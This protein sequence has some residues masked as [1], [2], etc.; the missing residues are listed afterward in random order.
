[1]MINTLS[2]I[3]LS[4][5]K[6]LIDCCQKDTSKQV[7]QYVYF[8]GI[9]ASSID[10]H[11]VYSVPY[12]H[13]E[14][15]FLVKGSDLKTMI[16]G[17][18]KDD[19]ISIPEICSYKK[20]ESDIGNFPQIELLIPNSFNHSLLINYMLEPYLANAINSVPMDYVALQVKNK[21][22]QITQGYQTFTRNFRWL[23]N[24][25]ELELGY[26]IDVDPLVF[27]QKYIGDLAKIKFDRIDIINDSSPVI[28]SS[29]N[30][31]YLLLMPFVSTFE[32]LTPFN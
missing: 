17:A 31:N 8:N 29:V 15:P 27:Q 28:F 6:M 12:V 30:G 32:K 25:L 24:P 22:I 21:M 7:L 9:T 23:N 2:K 3:S 16:K 20:Y 26:S 13:N 10:G 4:D 19:I 14:K 11:R 1:M 18:K 5:I